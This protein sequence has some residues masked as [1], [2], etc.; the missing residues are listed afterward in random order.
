MNTATN[1]LHEFMHQLAAANAQASKQPHAPGYLCPEAEAALMR[2]PD[3]IALFGPPEQTPARRISA[4]RQRKMEQ[5]Q[6]RR[7]RRQL[8]S[9]LLECARPMVSAFLDKL[10]ITGA[11]VQRAI[12]LAREATAILTK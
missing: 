2:H 4:N 9:Q 5:M 10:Q 1:P 8:E 7:A 6:R 12:N 3:M 11:D